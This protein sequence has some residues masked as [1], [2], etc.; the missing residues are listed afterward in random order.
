M[1]KK[2]IT[3]AAIII[4]TAGAL[5][6]LAIESA[7]AL[8]LVGGDN[9]FEISFDGNVNGFGVYID[10]DDLPSTAASTGGTL[11]ISEQDGFRVTTGY[12]PATLG[13]NVKAP[14]WK[15][16]DMGARIAFYPQIQNANR[17]NQF[18]LLLDSGIQ[19]GAQIDMREAYFTVE[20][21]FGK[22][23]IGR[24]IGIYMGTNVLRDMTLYGAGITVGTAFGVPTIGRIGVGYLYSNFNAVIQ[25]TTPDFG[26][27][28]VTAGIDDPSIIAGDG[29]TASETASPRG[30]GEISYA[31]KFGD[32]DVFAWF[33][34]MVQ[35]AEFVSGQNPACEALGG[36][37]GDVTVSGIGWGISLAYKDFAV[38][39]SGFDGDGAGTA[40]QLD[41]DSLDITGD[42]R[43]ANGYLFQGTYTFPNRLGSTK[44]GLQYG[45][46]NID[47]TAAESS[48]NINVLKER[49]AWTA[50]VYHDV[51]E[52]LKLI[53]EYTN[54]EQ[55]WFDG[56][57]Q[58]TNI[59]GVGAMFTW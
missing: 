27:F 14:T 19:A 10:G 48:G 25:Y 11:L 44:I 23:L 2:T 13:F 47:R 58:T 15:G 57:D 8:V 35:N 16:L 51:N 40:L 6:M 41:T 5:S 4:V 30:E 38:Q 52:W 34:G 32:A 17:K 9:G 3:R 53:A 1:G 50:G 54:F 18:G 24:K 26:G 36:C 49:T 56:S 59:V 39:A 29:V 22:A 21:S 20:G 31:R 7:S 42:K 43:D 33:S 55:K 45:Q 37:Q 46:T 28:K 12:L